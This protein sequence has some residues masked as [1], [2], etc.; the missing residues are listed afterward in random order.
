[1]TRHPKVTSTRRTICEVHRELHDIVFEYLPDEDIRRLALKKVDDAAAMG[2]SMDNK[3]KEYAYYVAGKQMA[4][5][6]SVSAYK[7][8]K[9]YYRTMR[10]R[11]IKVEDPYRLEAEDLR[12]GIKRDPQEGLVK[13][14]DVWQ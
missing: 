1:M 3:L 8:L 14:E 12:D 7:L 4:D 2:R 5:W 6:E 9:K 13:V 10:R 11:G